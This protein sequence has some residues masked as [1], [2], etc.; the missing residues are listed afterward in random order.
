[1]IGT[2]TEQEF[3]EYDV[4][5]NWHEIYRDMKNREEKKTKDLTLEVTLLPENRRKNRYRDVRPY[6]H[7]RVVLDGEEDYIN[8]NYIDVPEA[9]RKYILTQG[10]LDHTTCD[11]WQMTWEQNSKAIIMLNRVK[12]KGAIKCAQYW[13]LQYGDQVMDI[14]ECGLR[15]SFISEQVFKN[16]TV[17]ILELENLQTNE[18]RNIHH[19]HYTTWPDFGVPS[20]PD[21]F[22]HFLHCVRKTGLLSQKDEPPIIHCSAGIGRSGTFCLVESIL[23]KVEKDGSLK[24]IDVREDLIDM[25]H[26]RMGLI[27]T[28]DQLRFSYQ[29]IIQGAEAILNGD[30]LESFESQNPSEQI[31][32][33]EVPPPL[34]PKQQPID[35]SMLKDL[36]DDDISDEDFDEIIDREEE[37]EGDEEESDDEEERLLKEKERIRTERKQ[38]TLKKIEEMKDKQ[39]KSEKWRPF[40]P[41]I[42]STNVY[43]GLAVSAVIAGVVLYRYLS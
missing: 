37:S 39:K 24:N 16:F 33:E 26:F 21:A 8:A 22:L 34:P 7:S 23:V 17:R 9:D 42:N 29:A 4:Q 38:A 25:R 3:E 11:F 43:I 5:E 10:P 40:K 27:Q 19:F 31:P 32:F 41:Y 6:D 13:P 1:M 2:Q 36:S 28:A 18:K 35:P 14:V 12:E 15:V 20:S 30:G